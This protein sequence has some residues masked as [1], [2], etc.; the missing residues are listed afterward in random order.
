MSFIFTMLLVIYLVIGSLVTLGLLGLQLWRGAMLFDMSEN[1]ET[2][3]RYK[4]SYFLV[5]WSIFPIFYIAFIKEILALVASVRN[6][7]QS[8]LSLAKQ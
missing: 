4:V 8:N 2:P 6:G 7:E 1:G 5:M 3:F